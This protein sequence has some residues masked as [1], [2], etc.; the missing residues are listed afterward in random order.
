MQ[1]LPFTLFMKP[2]P[3]PITLTAGEPNGANAW[4]LSWTASSGASGYE[5]QESNSP[6]FDAATPIIVGPS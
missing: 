6:N 3:G 5:I 2:D 4:N 1:F